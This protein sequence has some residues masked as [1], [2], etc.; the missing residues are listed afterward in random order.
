VVLAYLLA[1]VVLVVFDVA[2]SRIFGYSENNR[3]CAGRCNQD[4]HRSD[5]IV[6]LVELV[7]QI[8]IGGLDGLV[9]LGKLV[10]LVDIGEL[11][12]LGGPGELGGLVE[13]IV[14]LPLLRN[15]HKFCC[16]K[17]DQGDTF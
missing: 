9:E 11:G 3:F 8:D 5:V 15:L 13:L 10:E 14:S 7:E 17:S 4:G 16:N 1:Y 2:K 12:E 6:E